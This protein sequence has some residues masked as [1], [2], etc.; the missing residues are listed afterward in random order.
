LKTE[1]QAGTARLPF[2]FFWEILELMNAAHLSIV[3]M[4]AL[5][6]ATPAFAQAD[7]R[8]MYASVLDKNGA[9]VLNLT[10]RDFI[11]R[12]DGQGREILR[13]TPDHDPLQ[14]ALLVDNSA[15]MSNSVAELR[16]AV[17]AFIDNTREGVQIALITLGERPTPAVGYT[18]DHAVLNQAAGRLFALPDAGNYLLDGIAESSQGLAKRTM[19]RSV[20]AVIT[21][22]A[23]LSYRQR[24]ETLR[25]FREGGAALHVLTL[26]TT[27][28]SADREMVVA[29]G[30]DETGG[31]NELVLSAM[32]LESK[33]QQLAA[34]L[35]NQY[36]V[37]YARPQRLIPPKDVEVSARRSD[38]R[39]RGMLLKT[40][41]E[42]Q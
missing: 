9:P 33:A 16:R 4:L 28:G 26:G 41:K 2:L 35:S 19:W 27:V 23:D 34:E 14:I 1:G 21:T 20:I 30:T 32:G 11:V 5:A 42:R 3:L 15:A 13:V 6:S 39:A 38:L 31:R 10:E 12:E 22:P 25:F 29:K 17:R 24:D 7:E 37:T 8:V 18:S 36:R 40:E